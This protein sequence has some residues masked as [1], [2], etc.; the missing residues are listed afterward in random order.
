MKKV[1][2]A[3]IVLFTVVSFTSCT[4]LTDEDE[5]IFEIHNVDREDI[6]RPGSQG[7]N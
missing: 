3:M 7:G 4:D 1:I 6:E 2:L 5:T